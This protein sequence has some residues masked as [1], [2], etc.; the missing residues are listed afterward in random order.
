MNKRRGKILKIKE[1]KILLYRKH[2][3][4]ACTCNTRRL[5]I[6]VKSSVMWQMPY[7]MGTTDINGFPIPTISGAR[8]HSVKQE[9]SHSVS[10]DSGNESH[11]CLCQQVFRNNTVRAVTKLGYKCALYFQHKRGSPN[12][13]RCHNLHHTVESHYK[14]HT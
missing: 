12:S 5:N 4:E 10:M 9:S 8:T 1:R 6:I 11:R 7:V 3:V 2:T 14:E 13:L